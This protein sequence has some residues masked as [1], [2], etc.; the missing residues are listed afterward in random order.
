MLRILII[1]MLF[2]VR[3]FYRNST[4]ELYFHHFLAS[5]KYSVGFEYP[6][7]YQEEI[8]LALQ[9]LLRQQAN[10]KTM[11]NELAAWRGHK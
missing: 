7:Q 9:T 8:D 5:I 1:L 10:I 6:K 2:V 3:K 11:E 4:I